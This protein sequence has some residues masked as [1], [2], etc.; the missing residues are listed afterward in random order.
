MAYNSTTKKSLLAL[1]GRYLPLIAVIILSLEESLVEIY[2]IEPFRGAGHCSIEPAQH[3]SC[4]RLIAKKE[5]IDKYRLP[6]SALRLVAGYGVSELDLQGIK[7]V[8]LTNLL[9]AFYLALDIQ[10][11]LLDLTEEAFALLARKRWRLGVKCIQ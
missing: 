9:Q 11:V 2:K 1:N 10:I 8:V 6:L 4:H 7:I 5:L 3:I